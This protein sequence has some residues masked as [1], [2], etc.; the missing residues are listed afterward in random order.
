MEGAPSVGR[1]RT[2]PDLSGGCASPPRPLLRLRF[3][4]L[5]RVRCSAAHA[6]LCH[7]GRDHRALPAGHCQVGLAG[8]RRFRHPSSPRLSNFRS[9]DD[10]G[11]IRRGPRVRFSAAPQKLRCRL[12]DPPPPPVPGWRQDSD[13][14]RG[15][16]GDQ[17]GAAGDGDSDERGSADLVRQWEREGDV[18]AQPLA[19]RH[20]PHRV[21]RHCLAQG[22]RESHAHGAGAGHRAV[23]G[24]VEAGGHAR[25]RCR[26]GQAV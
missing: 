2:E 3:Q 6:R 4:Q 9:G 1:C 23:P 13:R 11:R 19:A 5:P 16:D 20:A 12:H 10:P 7:G 26:G 25:E 17:R 14:E 21:R 22:R 18:S 8:H 24:A 15:G